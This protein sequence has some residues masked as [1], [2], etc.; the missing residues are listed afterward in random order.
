MIEALKYFKKDESFIMATCYT[1]YPLTVKILPTDSAIN[2]VPTTGMSGL[3]VGSRL[4]CLRY[5]NQLIAIANL[6]YPFCAR[7]SLLE[8]S[9]SVSSSTT[10]VDIDNMSMTI[11]NDGYYYR[12]HLRLAAISTS[13]VPN[14]KIAWRVDTG[15]YSAI[16]SRFVFGISGAGNTVVNTTT[17]PKASYYGFGT[18]VHYQLN[19]TNDEGIIHEYFVLKATS[20]T[21]TLVPQFAQSSSSATATQIV[22]GV[23]EWQKLSC[24]EIP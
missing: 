17:T 20:D 10:L 13:T 16:M 7:V 3:N 5:G 23:M 22:A 24:D 18:E 9:V 1:T 2:A 21:L 6:G 11:P 12:V 14:I 8:S 19:D 15:S 4:L